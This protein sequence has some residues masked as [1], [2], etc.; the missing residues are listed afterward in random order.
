MQ[1]VT[2]DHGLLREQTGI[3]MIDPRDLAYEVPPAPEAE[4][5]AALELYDSI[6][7]YSRGYPRLLKLLVSA[8]RRT[9]NNY[10]RE[11]VEQCR[12]LEA[13]LGTQPER[14]LGPPE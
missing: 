10:H 6:V 12:V 3:E 2:R 14:G 8:V 7:R 13:M 9:L 11:E 4:D 5:E 1:N